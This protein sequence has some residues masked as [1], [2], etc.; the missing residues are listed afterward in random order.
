M[1]YLPYSSRAHLFLPILQILNAFVLRKLP[2]LNAQVSILKELHKIKQ[3]RTTKVSSAVAITILIIGFIMWLVANH[4]H[5]P[6]IHNATPAHLT[7]EE[8]LI[9]FKEII[10]SQSA[11][12]REKNNISQ[13]DAILRAICM[14]LDALCKKYNDL[15]SFA[16][17]LGIVEDNY[18]HMHSDVKKFIHLDTGETKF[19]T[20]QEKEEFS[21]KLGIVIN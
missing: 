21:K 2:E 1:Y 17:V 13:E 10:R 20:P 18:P 11:D 14:L 12:M 19:E 5:K 9:M 4:Q 15:E 7:R 16:I 6:S 3:M 8:R